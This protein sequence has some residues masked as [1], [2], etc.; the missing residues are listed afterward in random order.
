MTADSDLHPSRKNG[1]RTT[2]EN[3]ETAL[4]VLDDLYSPE[5]VEIY[6]DM[7]FDFVWQDLEHAGP[8][9][10]D[11]PSLAHLLRAADAA[12]TELLVRIPEPDPA[13]VHKVLDT[14]VRNVF[15]S[16]VETAADVERAVKA[17]RF[18]YD[19]DPGGRGFANPRASRWGGADEYVET[20]DHEIMVGVT[21]EEPAAI[22]DIDGILAVPELDFV[23]VGP[24]DIAVAMGHPGD[25]AHPDV[26]EAVDRVVEAAREADVIIG[27][28][29]F[30]EDDVDE[31]IADGYRILHVGSTTGA[32]RETLQ[33][34]PEAF[35]S[36]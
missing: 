31:K 16:H 23:F 24:L 4:G 13:T 10:T 17:A 35:G 18:T 5:M 20:E 21:I 33:S 1:L 22:D 14:G 32:A 36:R 30:G 6:G 15:I 11:A 8:A 12:D 7:G 9:P 19:G 28:L 27:G 3:G 26:Q 2:I 34:W 29:G 25:V